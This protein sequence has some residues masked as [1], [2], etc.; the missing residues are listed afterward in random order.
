MSAL[1]G[2]AEVRE[3]ADQLGV[4]PTKRLGQNFV[5]DANTVRRIVAAAGLWVAL[6]PDPWRQPA[7][8]IVALESAQQPAPGPSAEKA[9][10]PADD[11]TAPTPSIIRVPERSE[12]KSG[13]NV[14]V[15]RDPSNE[16]GSDWLQAHYEEAH[17]EE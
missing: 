9:L 3:L 17:A 11:K 10:A 8:E 4:Q 14:I 13:S 2:P 5:H 7:A 12:A 15:I 1:L 6:L 16:Y